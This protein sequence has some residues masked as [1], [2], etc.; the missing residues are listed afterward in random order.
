M[1]Y[2]PNDP[3][4]KAAFQAA[5]EEALETERE[6][7]TAEV[8]RLNNK[9]KELLGK[10]AK[11]R[12]G[13]EGGVDTGEVE[14]LETE[15]ETVNSEL[16]TAQTALRET[17]RNLKKVEGERDTFRTQAETEATFSRNML[18][19]NALTTALVE[20]KVAPQYME[21]AKALL[22][23]GVAVEVNGDERTVVANG[24]P[25]ADF[26]KEWASGDAG[27]PFIQAPAN[28]GGGSTGANA[29]GNGG[30]KK[31]ADYTEQE[32]LDMAR[33]N[34]AGWQALLA[35]EQPTQAAA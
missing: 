8:E 22:S 9:N 4:T 6:T 24:K 33:T 17:A 1:A 10:L 32:R 35:S 11:A 34:P 2:D 29:N 31:L 3:E 18:T 16:R 14:R 15:L 7:H 25:L 28:G 20:A 23:K 13:G 19:E 27:K 30:T 5:I 26:V 21:A 12:K